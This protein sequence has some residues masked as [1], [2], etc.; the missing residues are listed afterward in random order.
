MLDDIMAYATVKTTPKE[1]SKKWASNL[2]STHMS[3]LDHASRGDLHLI[4]LED[5]ILYRVGGELEGMGLLTR[6]LDAFRIT[7]RGQHVL[8]AWHKMEKDRVEALIK[9]HEGTE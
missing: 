9:L 8:G 1:Y 2:S 4:G 5:Y 6:K 3:F 7:E